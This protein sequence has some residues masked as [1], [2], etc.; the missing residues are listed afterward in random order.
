M[1]TPLNAIELSNFPFMYRD[2]LPFELIT[3]TM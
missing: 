3:P 1:D 2:T